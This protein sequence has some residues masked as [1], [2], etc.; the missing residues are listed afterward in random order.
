MRRVRAGDIVV[1]LAGVL[2]LASMFLDWYSMPPELVFGALDRIMAGVTAWE[3]FSF[4]DLLLALVALLGIALALSNVLGRGPALPVA[5]A[6]I[7]TTLALASSL[8]LL[9]RIV[10]QPGPNQLVEV[11]AGAWVGLLACVGVFLGAWRSL[12]DERARPVD[13]A[14]PEPERRPTPARS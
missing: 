6:V 9:Y 3:A 14:P 5:L 1:G 7:T 10:N 13:P 11:S 2:L 12:G 4:M 8:L